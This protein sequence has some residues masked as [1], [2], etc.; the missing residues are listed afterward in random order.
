MTDLLHR[1]QVRRNRAGRGRRWTTAGLALAG[2]AFG[3]VGLAAMLGAALLGDL[4]QGLPP[5]EQIE[6]VFDP[7]N[8]GAPRSTLWLD[9][10]GS[11]LLYEAGSPAAADRRG[12]SL[13][14]AS[15]DA[16]PAALVQ[17]TVA[18]A[19]PGFWEHRGY[20]T[21]WLWRSVWAGLTGQPLPE[22]TTI[23]QRLVRSALAPPG[24]AALPPLARALREAL[25]ASELT[26]TYDRQTILTWYLNAAY[27]GEAAYGA[28]AAALVYFGKHAAEL[29]LSE[30]A[31]LAGLPLDPQSNPFAAPQRAK[32]QQAAVLEALLRLGLVPVETAQAALSEPLQL[33][34]RPP[35]PA[36]RASAFTRSAMQQ[37]QDRFGPDF[38][39]RSGLRI[40][41]TLDVDLQL[42]AE[43]VARTQLLRLSGGE[44]GAVESAA[45]GTPCVAAGLL[46]PL[47]PGDA[48]ADH[49][50]GGAGAVVL[51]PQTGV[52]L[53][54]IE[55]GSDDPGGAAT[56]LPGPALYPF[57]Y[58]AGFAR[59][60]TP[61]SMALDIPTVFSADDGGPGYAPADDDGVFHGPVRTRTAL[62]NLYPLAA[63]RAAAQVGI[64]DVLRTAR[65][66]GLTSLAEPSSQ[67]TLRSLLEDTRV[68]MIDLASAL[69]VVAH[70]GV[71]AG[72]AAPGEGDGLAPSLL[73]R[74]TNDAGDLLYAYTPETRAVLSAPLAYLMT[75]VLS[76]EAARWPS[77]GQPNPLEVG[78]PAGAISGILLD[79]SGAWAIG[80]TPSRVLV[81]WMGNDS[82]AAMQAVT[83]T[84]GPAAV[85]HAVLR[86]AARD[87]PA[88]GWSMPAGVSRV[89]VC[90]P[91]GLLPTAYCPQTV[92]EVFLQGTEPI[93]ADSL[94]RPLQVNRETGKL[95]TLYTPLDLIEERVY[96]MVPAEAQAWAAQ[97]GLERPPTEYDTLYVPPFDPRVNIA[98]PAAFAVIRGQVEIRGDARPVGFDYY[99]LQ[100]GEGLN[101]ASWV[102]IGEDQ[103]RPVRS[104][105]LGLWDT[106][107]LRGLY[108]LQ[109]LVVE[110]EGRVS[111]AA[112]Q[113]TVDNTPP[114]LRVVLPAEGQAYSRALDE[115]AIL[116]VE[117]GDNLA[118]A[119]VAFYV[120]GVSVG[121]V[122]GAPYSLRWPLGR[123]GEHT[124]YARAADVAGNA[125]DSERVTFR[126]EP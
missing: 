76:D 85:W 57:I 26:H 8:G 79:D 32:A 60:T 34:A 27:Y 123:V 6:S 58:L 16:A 126:V 47:R 38:L 69:G 94:Y 65:Q 31:L 42:Q 98:S 77:L 21:G 30:C 20:E 2:A 104:G 52:V 86:Y 72:A 92:S 5:V 7:A 120:D 9:R 122:G 24:D 112:V 55:I 54:R 28:D 100:Y 71:M 53:A 88:Q 51:N 111:T 61:A 116:Q 4:R 15:P 13:N 103:P 83:A 114:T 67:A 43:C 101:P 36:M 118:L 110:D 102:Q 33:A 66:M 97:A 89:E 121:E 119:R 99:R 75:D 12:V 78:R 96:L 22:G 37:L 39:H 19:D 56:R 11:V 81:V 50:I 29:D 63:A 10:S 117:A 59:G 23:T 115:A 84:N 64:G 113:V 87:L 49:V 73:L 68:G 93:H 3:V 48:R 40:L 108:T 105:R 14:P 80:F 45:D 25:L 1:R 106:A 95:A 109:L 107:G 91:S 41:T 70:G 62:A 18:F 74:I 17:A 35:E 90:D 44:P 125:A 82:G 124:A 46:P